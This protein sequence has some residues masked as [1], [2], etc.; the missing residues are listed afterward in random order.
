[1]NSNFK[2][3]S[4]FFFLVL[5][6]S[7]GKVNK[8]KPNEPIGTNPISFLG[9]FETFDKNSLFANVEESIDISFPM[10]LSDHSISGQKNVSII[11]LRNNAN[12]IVCDYTLTQSGTYS[13]NA[14]CVDSHY[15]KN[16][17]IKPKKISVSPTDRIVVTNVTSISNI[18]FI[19]H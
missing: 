13:A 18:N 16:N 19:K 1:M 4:L 6:Y 10:T 9:A 11:I 14:T 17:S 12:Q 2:T 7:C 3:Y 5:L 15:L 8:T